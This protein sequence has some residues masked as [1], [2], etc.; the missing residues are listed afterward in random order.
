[1]NSVLSS[2]LK[3][4]IAVTLL[5]IAA[6]SVSTFYSD[7]KEQAEVNNAVVSI[8]SELPV[9]ELEVEE[10]KVVAKTAAPVVLAAAAQSATVTTVQKTQPQVTQA[11]PKRLRIPS[12]GVDAHVEQVGL[13]SSGN[14]DAPA[15]PDNAGWYKYGVKPGEVGSA[16]IDGHSGWRDNIPAIFDNLGN[17]KV[18]DK[19]YVEGSDGTTTTFVVRDIREYGY[20][21]DAYEIFNSSDGLAH[22]NLITCTGEWND[23]ARSSL[24]RLVVFAD[25][26]N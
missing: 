18:G 25:K 6:Y 17:V 2:K 23:I 3:I 22:L 21:D 11:G 7:S 19:I 13:T 15:G 20:N 16:V 9:E 24:K 8:E 4:I 26:V 10:E 12:I 14:M 1:M 5:A